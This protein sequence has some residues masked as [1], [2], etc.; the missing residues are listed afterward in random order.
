MHPDT[1]IRQEN[2]RNKKIDALGGDSNSDETT[3]ERLAEL[4]AVKFDQCREEEAALELVREASELI[5]EENRLAIPEI[6][7]E[8]WYQRPLGMLGLTV[9]AGLIVAYLVFFFGWY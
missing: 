3:I 5:R 7:P 9:I 2:E 1:A 8:K 4:S 6:P